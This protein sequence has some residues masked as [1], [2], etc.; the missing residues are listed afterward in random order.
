MI[1]YESLDPTELRELKVKALRDIWAFADLIDFRGGKESFYQLHRDMTEMNCKTQHMV[2]TKREWRRRIFLIPRE[3]R[4]STVN[5][6]LYSLWRVY[7]NPNIRIVIMCNVKELALDMIREMRSYFEDDDLKEWVWN[8]RPH[9]KGNL[10]PRLRTASSNYKRSAD[11]NDSEDAKVIWTAYALQVVRD[12]KDKQPTI[13]ALSV[14]MKPT[15]KH[16]DLVIFDDIVDWDNSRTPELA[17]KVRRSAAEIESV[18]TK[19]AERVTICPGFQEWVGNEIL[20]N[21]TRYYEYDYYSG[22]VGNSEE[23]QRERLAIRR[24]SAMVLDVYKNGV[25]NSDGYICPEIL[26]EE[27]ERD[28]LE[29]ESITL[30]EWYAQYRNKII[31]EDSQTFDTNMIR[32]VYHTDYVRTS[33]QAMCNFIDRQEQTENG[34]MVYPIRLHMFCDLATGK[35]S[36]DDSVVTVGGWDEKQR[37]HAVDM[38]AGK[39]P[40]NQ[41]FGKIMH[42]ADKWGIT[43]VN[44]EGGVGYQDSFK[45]SLMNWLKLNEKRIL[46]A[47]GIPVRRD[48]DKT[49]RI[50]I[51]LEPLVKLGSI[52]VSS[53]IWVH[54]PLKLEFARFNLDLSRRKDNCLDTLEML[55]TNT[56]P[57]MRRELRENR[58]VGKHVAYNTLFGGTR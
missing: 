30:R 39:F 18:V 22:I 33:Q 55:A 28:L 44:Y 8:S 51:A 16:C 52:C 5:T 54:Q 37:L 1:D 17:E 45:D 3:H 13:Q 4:K 11:G 2:E 24:Y 26:D 32:V 25:D 46:F 40:P 42:L 43:I 9:I 58:D 27:V 19:K 20:I 36:S 34:P 14:G 53:H 49:E 23:E 15:G 57:M 21:G 50:R 31:N 56:K 47:N 10:I 6:V 48:I 38:M 12:L 7:R 35:R 41:F 29:S